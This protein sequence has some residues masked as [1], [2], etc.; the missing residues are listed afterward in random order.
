MLGGKNAISH[1]LK[2]SAWRVFYFV[3]QCV[4]VIPGDCFWLEWKRWV[5]FWLFYPKQKKWEIQQH[6]HGVHP[7]KNVPSYYHRKIRE[8]LFLHI[9][10]SYKLQQYNA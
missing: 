8:L 7:N 1:G 5:S 6:E 3:S 2:H 4:Y 10:M 9:H